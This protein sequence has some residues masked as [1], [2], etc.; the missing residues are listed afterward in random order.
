MYRHTKAGL[1]ML[2]TG[3]LLASTVIPAFAEEGGPGVVGGS[4]STTETSSGISLSGPG[5]DAPQGAQETAE[6]SSGVITAGESTEGS[7]ETDGTTEGT[8]CL[9]YTSRCV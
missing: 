5:G 9:L 7:S 8:T 4:S 3:A 2:L 6:S 1:A